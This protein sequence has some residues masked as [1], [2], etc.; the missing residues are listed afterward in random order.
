MIGRS[1]AVYVLQLTTPCMHGM[2][3]HL[4]PRTLDLPHGLMADLSKM[5]RG[6]EGMNKD[7]QQEAGHTLHLTIHCTSCMRYT[8]STPTRD[9]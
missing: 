7:N 9:I 1:K 3:L 5:H 8:I 4:Q 6:C 2:A